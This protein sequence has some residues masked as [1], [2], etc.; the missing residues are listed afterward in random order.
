MVEIIEEKSVVWGK[1]LFY[2][3]LFYG[4]VPRYKIE[5]PLIFSTNKI[6]GCVVFICIDVLLKNKQI[7]TNIA[8]G[9]Q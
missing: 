6:E 3:L 9:F 2:S 7:L 4:I 8:F 1:T 5:K